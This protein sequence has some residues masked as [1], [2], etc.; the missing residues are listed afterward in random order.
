M[1]NI[2]TAMV[3]VLGSVLHAQDSSPKLTDKTLSFKVYLD[4]NINKIV[5]VNI[6]VIAATVK[7]FN[8]F[9]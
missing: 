3:I 2:I 5:Y 8:P 1:K 7:I 4:Y 6:N 9:L